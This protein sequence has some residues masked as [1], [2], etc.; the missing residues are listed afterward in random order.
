MKKTL[1]LALFA[2]GL[3]GTAPLQ[4]AQVYKTQ[5]EA[6]AAAT[7]DGYILAVYAEG[8]DRFSKALCRKLTS[9]PEILEAA[10]DAAIIMAPFYQY[11]GP[12]EKARQAEVWG[13]LAEPRSNS[14]ETYPSLLMYDK[15]GF[16]Y[17]RV[18]GT[19][20]IKGSMEEIAAEV[21]AK[22]EA[23]RRQAE[24]MQQADATS[25]VERAMLIAQACE[26]K[27]IE[28]PDNYRNL[29]RDADPDDE[30]G[31]NK[32]LNFDPWAFAQKYCGKKSDGGLELDPEETVR[33]MEEHI[34]DPAY[35]NEQKQVFHAV[36]V[37]TLRRS[38]KGS[39]STRMRSNLMD[40][41][42]LAPDSNLGVTADQAIKIWLSGD[43]EKK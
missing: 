21:K 15:N 17:G 25:G 30:S 32:R 35:T 24:L 9:A 36:I 19:L 41:K 34:K 40:M 3:A 29:V 7:D 38:S 4:A 18:Q 20:L 12:E 26:L 43:K 28:R 33:I 39:A 1:Y 16:L 37:G 11:S 27:G 23:K 10:G 31:M 2:L 8:W 6:A 5:A 42:R 22:L 13:S 14:M